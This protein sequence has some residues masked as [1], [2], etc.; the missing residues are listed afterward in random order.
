[1]DTSITFENSAQQDKRKYENSESLPDRSSSPE[2]ALVSGTQEDWRTLYRYDDSD[3]S[4]EERSNQRELQSYIANLSDQEDIEHTVPGQRPA[5]LIDS[6]LS[7]IDEAMLDSSDDEPAPV[8]PP[9]KKKSER[10]QKSKSKHE[11]QKPIKKLRKVKKTT[12]TA[13]SDNLHNIEPN[14]NESTQLAVQNAAVFND[15]VSTDDDDD[16]DDDDD[17]MEKINQGTPKAQQRH[18]GLSKKD[19]LEM[20]KETQ[21]LLRQKLTRLE[22]ITDH[23]DINDFLSSLCQP[24]KLPNATSKLS[25]KALGKLPQESVTLVKEKRIIRTPLPTFQHTPV[26]TTTDITSAMAD[27]ELIIIDSYDKHDNELQTQRETPKTPVKMKQKFAQI[28]HQKQLEVQRPKTT[29]DMT[30]QQLNHMLK[31]KITQQTSERRQEAEDLAKRLGVWQPPTQGV[32]ELAREKERRKLAM[33]TD[34]DFIP[35]SD[36]EYEEDEVNNKEHNSDEDDIIYSGEETNDDDN[37][38]TDIDED[39]SNDAVNDN[40]EGQ[41]RI[42]TM[43]SVLDNEIT[44]LVTSNNSILLNEIEKDDDEEEEEEK[45]E[46]DEQVNIASKSINRSKGRH[47][48]L[49]IDSDE[50]TTMPLP[51]STTENESNFSNIN[52]D[53]GLDNAIFAI[54]D[55]S[56]INDLSESTLNRRLIS[57][58]NLVADMFKDKVKPMSRRMAGYFDAEAEEEEDEWAGFLDQQQPPHQ[59]EP[60][61]DDR[62]DRFMDDID[63]VV[64]DLS[65]EE[66]NSEDVAALH[67][68]QMDDQDAAEVSNLI[69]DLKEGTLGRSKLD[70]HGKG[71]GLDGSDDDDDDGHGNSL[72]RRAIE[73]QST[74]PEHRYEVDE[75][76]MQL[77]KNPATAAFARIAL[78]T[79]DDIDVASDDLNFLQDDDHTEEERPRRARYSIMDDQTINGSIL[80]NDDFEV[81]DWLFKQPNQQHKAFNKRTMERSST[82]SNENCTTS[83]IGRPNRPFFL[84]RSPNKRRRFL[85]VTDNGTITKPTSQR[86]N[87]TLAT[88]KITANN[89]K[90]SQ[91]SFV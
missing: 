73:W 41:T 45:E 76:L 27:M 53:T 24:I 87:K 14:T 58:R 1:M 79:E 33:G 67:R 85:D 52:K 18:K 4:D 7:D 74:G 50:E 83:L 8:K 84:D 36:E 46:E 86:T 34:I 54:E 90:T 80:D 44:D 13:K 51:L 82:L 60:E 30:P 3:G 37:N 77:E 35:P 11:R 47:H 40:G 38:N 9:V 61:E 43:D 89:T 29:T 17:L 21:R 71:F 15:A 66:E 75:Q 28:K 48:T 49:M 70:F 16:D 81:E 65:D 25:D 72:N 10:Q 5:W 2:L 78:G 91:R 42:A 64:H 12:G 31:A 20:H 68:K 63:M 56:N 6:D 26:C 23:L 39:D 88:F 62:D 32:S 19:Q 57:R 22:S 55:D 69:R 59:N